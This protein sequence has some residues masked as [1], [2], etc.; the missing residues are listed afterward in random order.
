[1]PSLGESLAALVTHAA[2]PEVDDS[3]QFLAFPHF[4]FPVPPRAVADPNDPEGFDLIHK[5]NMVP[6]EAPVFR[7]SADFLWRPYRDLLEGRILPG[8]SDPQQGFASRFAAAQEMLEDGLM[9]PE[10][11]IWHPV[12]FLPSAIETADAWTRA[13]LGADSIRSLA[14]AVSAANKEWLS[15]FNTL[16]KFGDDFI[17]SIHYEHLA[18]IVVRPWLDSSVFQWRFWKHPGAPFSDGGNPPRGRLPGAAVK[19]ILIRN[20]K[21][22]LAP[23][24]LPDV[25][26][27]IIFKTVGGSPPPAMGLGADLL[28]LSGAGAERPKR[29]RSSKADPGELDERIALLTARVDAEAGGDDP[30]FGGGAQK[31]HVPFTFDVSGARQVAQDGLAAAEADS[32]ALSSGIASSRQQIATLQQTIARSGGSIF[33]IPRPQAMIAKQELMKAQLALA[34][35]EEG[36]RTTE[37]AKRRWNDALAVLRQLDEAEVAAGPHVLALV[38]DRFPK[39]PDPDPELFAAT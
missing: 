31:F 39:A 29:R 15:R 38:C 20:L 16:V 22:K 23:K 14:G 11:H 18:L 30:N 25:G 6:D 10:G 4:F 12:S 36:L 35:S 26:P 37:A 9:T 24:P 3:Q 17:E 5:V 33:G 34:M 28:K 13:A 2:Q 1:M 8:K 32:Q 7:L 21:M 27:S 19:L